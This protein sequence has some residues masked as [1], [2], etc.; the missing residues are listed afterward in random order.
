MIYPKIDKQKVILTCCLTG[1]GT[2]EQIRGL[3]DDSIPSDID[4]TVVS[5]DYD[6]LNNQS[7]ADALLDGYD[8]LGV[9]GTVNPKLSGI[10]FI[11]LEEVVSGEAERKMEKIL[12]PV[13]SHERIQEI[14][15]H[16]VRN[17]SVRQLIGSLTIL[18][19]D[20][21]MNHIEDCLKQYEVTD[22]KALSNSTK[23][24]LFIH[25]GCLVERLIRRSP[26]EDY[27]DIDAF[28]AERTEEIAKIRSAFS[29]IENTY[30]VKIP[31]YEI[32]YIYDIINGI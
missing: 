3:I 9:I 23:I 10:E 24:N 22:G 2:A 17:F 20:K 29:G 5:Y 12:S 14:N 8:I 21:I 11:P 6:Q 15:D 18:D 27:P 13:I 30:S 4:I 31:L 7:T 32:G 26:I 28:E 1:T 16:L 19:T 25:V